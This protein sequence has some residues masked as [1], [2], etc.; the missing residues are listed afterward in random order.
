MI[1]PGP[2]TGLIRLQSEEIAK[3]H[4]T[5]CTFSNYLLRFASEDH[6]DWQKL[7]P[8]FSMS[9]RSLQYETKSCDVTKRKINKAPD[10]FDIWWECTCKMSHIFS[11]VLM[12]WRTDFERF[13]NLQIA[14]DRMN[15]RIEQNKFQGER[16]YM[17]IP[18]S[19]VN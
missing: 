10:E 16:C 15:I 18:F 2:R 8:P 12:I 14:S 1:R 19:K 5:N 17:T 6:W 9:Y 3:R 7:G 11:V 13:K 4:N